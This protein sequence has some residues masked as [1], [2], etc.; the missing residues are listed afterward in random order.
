MHNTFP[1]QLRTDFALV[2]VRCPRE[3]AGKQIA[4]EQELAATRYLFTSSLSCL[5][6][7]LAANLRCLR[8]VEYLRS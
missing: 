4:V 7:C 8:Q 2:S 1:I 5:A 6:P 3:T